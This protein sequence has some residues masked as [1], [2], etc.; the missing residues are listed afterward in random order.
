MGIVRKRKLAVVSDGEDSA[1]EAPSPP[2]Q[3][4]AKRSGTKAT[5]E[6]ASKVNKKENKTN[7][8]DEEY[9]TEVRETK[10]GEKYVMLGPKRR[11]TVREFKGKPLVDIR[12]FYVDKGTG[13]EKPGNKGIA[14]SIE[15]WELLKSSVAPLIDDL[16]S[17]KS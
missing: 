2:P 17:K 7:D 8:E 5:A 13:E 10:E 11:V 14:L 1:A 16:L 12:E 15:Q 3:Q 6:E 4:K 9:G